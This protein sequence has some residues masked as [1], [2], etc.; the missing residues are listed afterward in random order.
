ME[1]VFKLG[2]R[3]NCCHRSH[4]C[5]HPS[6]WPRIWWGQVEPGKSTCTMEGKF[7]SSLSRPLRWQTRK[8]VRKQ[9]LPYANRGN[10]NSNVFIASSEQRCSNSDNHNERPYLALGSLLEFGCGFPT[11]TGF[12]L[13]SWKRKSTSNNTLALFAVS[14]CSCSPLPGWH[15]ETTTARARARA[16]ANWRSHSGSQLESKPRAKLYMLLLDTFACKVVALGR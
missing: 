4:I 8:L 2:G 16:R 5:L 13:M 3:I 7:A 11:L 1:E 10:N 12:G 14:R 9:H 15:R 6:T